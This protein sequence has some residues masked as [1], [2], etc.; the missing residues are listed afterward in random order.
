MSAAALSGTRKPT[1]DSSLFTKSPKPGVSTTV[2][3]SLTPP[4]SMS[5]RTSSPSSA[6]R[7]ALLRSSARPPRR[8]LRTRTNLLDLHGPSAVRPGEWQLL[9]PVQRRLEEG[10][11]EGRLAKAG[12]AWGRKRAG[13]REA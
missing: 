3:L 1:H 4:S 9:G 7:S 11:D 8:P 6:S 5:V 12:F 10:V 13:G 2:N